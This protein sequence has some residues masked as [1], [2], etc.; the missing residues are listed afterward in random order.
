M[1]SEAA[2]A[3]PHGAAVEIYTWRFCP[4][5]IRAKGLLDRK[6][7]EYREYGIDG[8]DQARQHM[9]RRA[10]GRSSLP[11]IFINNQPIGGCDELHALERRGALD[12]LLGRQA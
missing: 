10:G 11:Q 12:A 2:N 6:G 7:V 4:F 5:C 1:E 3:A 8:D 9:T